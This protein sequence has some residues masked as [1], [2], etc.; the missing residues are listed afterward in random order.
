MKEEELKKLVDE[1]LKNQLRASEEK[2]I[3]FVLSE[4]ERKKILEEQKIE[5]LVKT[6][7]DAE[8]ARQKV[9]MVII[10]N[11]EKQRKAK[12]VITYL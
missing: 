11:E 10:L 12:A 2:Q 9:Y 7:E 3:F 1:N 4:T 8:K 6:R 5:N